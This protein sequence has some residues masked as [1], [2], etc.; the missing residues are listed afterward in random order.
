MLIVDR[1]LYGKSKLKEYNIKIWNLQ[2]KTKRYMLKE[3]HFPLI[4]A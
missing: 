4:T 1:E 3:I 2:H